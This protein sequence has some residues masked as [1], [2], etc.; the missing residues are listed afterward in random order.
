ME[1]VMQEIQ[2]SKISE[3]IRAGFQ[4]Y[5][6]SFEGDHFRRSADGIFEYAVVPRG[7]QENNQVLLREV[8]MAQG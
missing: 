1:S 4:I 8:E 2:F 7:C 5:D 3:A 6:R